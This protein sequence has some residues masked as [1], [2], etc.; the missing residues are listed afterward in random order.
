MKYVKIIRNEFDEYEVWFKEDLKTGDDS[1][2]YY[3]DDRDDA[4]GTAS[5][6]ENEAAK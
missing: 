3:T 5:L 2:T 4:K 1:R 6:M